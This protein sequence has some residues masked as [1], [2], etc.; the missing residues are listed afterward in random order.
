MKRRKKIHFKL[1]KRPFSK[2]VFFLWQSDLLEKMFYVW[3]K[4]GK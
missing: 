2:M 1:K 4:K 3:N